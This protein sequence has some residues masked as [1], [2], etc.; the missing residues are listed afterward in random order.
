[1][2]KVA[3]V[4][5][6]LQPGGAETMLHRVLS[7]ID[8]SSFD[9][10]VISMTGDGPIGDRI[11]AAGFPVS[12]LGMKPGVPNPTGLLRLAQWL[13]RSN[14]DVVQTWMYHAD[15]LG[16]LAAKLAGHNPLVV[17][18]IRHGDPGTHHKRITRWTVRACAALSRRIPARIVCCS[19]VACRFHGANG[20]AGDKMIVIPN[21]F[22]IHQFRPDPE[23]RRSVR[24]ELGITDESPLVGLI[25]HVRPQKDHRNFLRAA[26]LIASQNPRAHF[27]LCGSGATWNHPQLSAWIDE[28]DIRGRCHLLGRR[29]DVAAIAAALDVAVSS[30]YSEGFPNA[31]GEA[32]AC[33]VPCVVTN[34]GDSGYLV[35]DTGGVVPPS[36]PEALAQSCLELLRMRPQERLQLGTAARRR[37]EQH[38]GLPAIIA[39]YEALYREVARQRTAPADEPRP[40]VRLGESVPQ[41]TK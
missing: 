26:A 25:G 31:V 1:M 18:N 5:T 41:K 6:D 21:G 14:C 37:I 4:I 35:N 16:G 7:G 9:C 20:F 22:D 38:F 28:A 8:T 40:W 15:L 34:V 23:A 30:S 3:H 11:R 19:R 32:M 17:W 33:G 12:V 29:D 10:K 13:R 27:V 39:R 2:I 36:D 24:T